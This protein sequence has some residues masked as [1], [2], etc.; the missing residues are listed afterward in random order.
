ML[1]GG[2]LQ[3]LGKHQDRVDNTERLLHWKLS[4]SAV[5]VRPKFESHVFH[6]IQTNPTNPTR[7][8]LLFTQSAEEKQRYNQDLEEA[9]ARAEAATRRKVRLEERDKTL[10]ESSLDEPQY[11]ARRRLKSAVNAVRLVP[12]KDSISNLLIAIEMGRVDKVK[13]WLAR[14]GNDVNQT[15]SDANTLLHVCDPRTRNQKPHQELNF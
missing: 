8:P 1:R 13:R 10:A 9:K 4:G 2:A 14:P 3:R 11:L 6:P 12:L 15:D 7:S 5:R